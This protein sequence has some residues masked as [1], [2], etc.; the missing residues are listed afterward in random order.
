MAIKVDSSDAGYGG[1]YRIERSGDNADWKLANARPGEKLEI[2]RAN[3]ASYVLGQVPLA[4][5]ATGDVKDT[6]TG[7]EKP[8]LILATTLDGK[9]YELKVGRLVGENYYVVF[10]SPQVVVLRRRG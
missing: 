6:D 1:G 10:S 5:V 2:T 4:D 9:S 3:A 8:A 7:L